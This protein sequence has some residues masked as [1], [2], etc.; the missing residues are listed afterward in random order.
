[1]QQCYNIMNKYVVYFYTLDRKVEAFGVFIIT[2]IDKMQ[3][4][5]EY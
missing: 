5:I 4:S 1:M 2:I 3:T